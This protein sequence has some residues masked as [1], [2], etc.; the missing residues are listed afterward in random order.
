MCPKDPYDSRKGNYKW[1]TAGKFK[2]KIDEYFEQL[3]LEE[4]APT[5]S[6]L[7]DYL[8]ITRKTFSRYEKERDELRPIIK[9]A[10][11]RIESIINSQSLTGKYVA[12]MAKFNLKN[13]FGWE[14]R[15]K[16]EIMGEGGGPVETGLDINIEKAREREEKNN[17]K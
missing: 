16:E 15:Q 6:G 8:D 14:D 12:S 17:E 1:K 11:Q 13:N 10:K 4:D 2:N 7:C 9:K 5:V 3:D